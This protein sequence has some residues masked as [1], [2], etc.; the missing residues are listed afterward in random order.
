ML[1]AFRKKAKGFTLI[2]ILITISIIAILASLILGGVTIARKK[3]YTTLAAN[4][5]NSLYSNLKRYV[6]DTGKY[7]GAEYPDGEN[8]FPA[9]FEALFDERPPK[10]K[11]GPSA[12]YLE[13]REKEVGVWDEDLRRELAMKVVLGSEGQ[14]STAEIAP[15]VLGRFLEEAQVTGQ[16]DH[17][18]IVPVHELGLDERTL[19]LFS[20]DNG[21]TTEGGTDRDF[22]DSNG[23]HRGGKGE[24]Y[25]GGIRAPL[26]ARWPGKIPTGRVCNEPAMNIDWFPTCLALAGLDPPDDRIIDGRN[27]WPQDLEYLAE[28]QPEARVG[29][30]LAFSVPGPENR[31]ICVLVVQ[32][33]ENNPARREALIERLT[34]LVRSEMGIDCYVE[35]VPPHTLPRTSSGKLSRSKARQNFMSTHDLAEVAAT[36]EGVALRAAAG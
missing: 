31:E 29:D 28:H 11:G 21:P 1:K 10:G 18:G 6:Q 22:F 35:L 30:A 9:L 25:E 27:I 33:R 20:S 5:V 26:I 7:P 34:R 2:E 13:L 12:P 32:C 8:A 3:A 19:V 24:L 17:P 23:A 15:K 14:A 36:A 4:T 16:L